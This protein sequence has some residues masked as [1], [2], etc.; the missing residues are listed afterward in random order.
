MAAMNR[1]PSQKSLGYVGQEVVWEGNMAP[2]GPVSCKVT[3]A[4]KV[5]S[6]ISKP[7][8]SQW[9]SVRFRLKPLDGSRA[10]WTPS[11]PDEQYETSQ[12]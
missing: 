6:V 1:E 12:L 11:M 2:Y 10:F 7:D 3:D 4:E 5:F 8:G 9:S